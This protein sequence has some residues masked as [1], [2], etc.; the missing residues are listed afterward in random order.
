MDMRQSDCVNICVMT[1]WVLKR[2]KHCVGEGGGGGGE[3]C[4]V[5]GCFGVVVV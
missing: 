2:D 5:G 3:G 1:P 4:W